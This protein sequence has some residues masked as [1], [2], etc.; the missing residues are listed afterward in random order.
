MYNSTKIEHIFYTRKIFLLKI[1]WK[2]FWIHIEL[3]PIYEDWK[4][5][6]TINKFV[7]FLF[8]S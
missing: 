7:I 3:N 5:I 1:E 4:W 6:H 2:H 8:C